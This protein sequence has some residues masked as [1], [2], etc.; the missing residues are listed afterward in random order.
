MWKESLV[1]KDETKWAKYAFWYWVGEIG[2][3]NYSWY[4]AY[5]LGKMTWDI[6]PE[7]QR[8][9]ENIYMLC[10]IIFCWAAVLYAVKKLEDKDCTELKQP[11]YDAAKQSDS[12]ADP[13]KPAMAVGGT[14]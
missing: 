8:L 12:A 10:V 14:V 7:G 6:L 9:G 5:P 13:E 1:I 4:S 2:Y 3:C 11:A